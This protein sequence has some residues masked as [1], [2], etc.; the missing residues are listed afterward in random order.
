MK[1]IFSIPLLLAFVAAIAP[2]PAR[3]QIETYTDTLKVNTTA[4]FEVSFAELDSMH[5]NLNFPDSASGRVR[6]TALARIGAKRVVLSTDTAMVA[7]FGPNAGASNVRIPWHR[8]KD[9][10]YC[11]E[12][13]GKLNRFH[14][15]PTAFY[16][17]VVFFND[18]ST[19][20]GFADQ[21][22]KYFQ[23]AVRKF[24]RSQIGVLPIVS[25]TDTLKKSTT[26]SMI[27]EMNELDSIQIIANYQDSASGRIRVQAYNVVKGAGTAV[28]A[29]TALATLIIGKNIGGGQTRVSYA[30]L[31]GL[32]THGGAMPWYVKIDLLFDA[33]VTA[34]GLVRPI[35]LAQLD[36]RRF[37]HK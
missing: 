9:T 34:S 31:S 8:I 32:R 29:D 13:G 16:V 18:A 25:E 35:K 22:V 30:Q 36:V 15:M 37:R 14:V 17:D 3:A 28:T 19:Y 2:A 6:L 4:R 7:W 20:G 1:R 12:C 23:L 33:T 26:M 21:S 5:L 11:D 24:R 10:I 27:V